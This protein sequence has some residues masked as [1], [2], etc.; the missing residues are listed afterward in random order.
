[1]ICGLR[2]TVRKLRGDRHDGEEL[3]YMCM[4]RMSLEGQKQESNCGVRIKV[5]HI[6]FDGLAHESSEELYEICVPHSN[7]V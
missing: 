4:L 5:W 3:V 6:E 1:M 7:K 2:G